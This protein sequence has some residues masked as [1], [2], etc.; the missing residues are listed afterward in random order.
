ME[1]I[2]EL[3]S[4]ETCLAPISFL[5]KTGTRLNNLSL[6]FSGA[7]KSFIASHTVLENQ[8]L[9]PQCASMWA[10]TSTTDGIHFF[11][12]DDVECENEKLR[13]AGIDFE[14]TRALTFLT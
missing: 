12:A 7:G 11:L 13:F 2:F 8:A 5:A 6:N 9:K 1:T 14:G 10:T 3:G 4:D